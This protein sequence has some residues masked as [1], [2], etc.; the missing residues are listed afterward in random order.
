MGS[1]CPTFQLDHFHTRT[2]LFWSDSKKR[3]DWKKTRGNKK[4]C[5][6]LNL[7]RQNFWAPNKN[8]PRIFPTISCPS[9][10]HPPVRMHLNYHQL[11]TAWLK[12]ASNESR[13]SENQSAFSHPPPSSYPWPPP[14]PFKPSSCPFDCSS[15]NSTR[16]EFVLITFGEAIHV[17]RFAGRFEATASSKISVPLRAKLISTANL[18][19]LQ[20]AVP[21]ITAIP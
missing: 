19:L 11:S 3:I 21:G 20:R 13:S 1:S 10:S 4:G 14:Y 7:T 17:H 9:F 12:Y 16:P 8:A 15:N 2:T 6:T 18:G 5:T